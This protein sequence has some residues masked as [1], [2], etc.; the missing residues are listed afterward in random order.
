[1]TTDTE[2]CNRALGQAGARG[3]ITNMLT[4]TSPEAAACRTYYASTRNSL[5]RA[6]H[7]DFARFAAYVNVL[8]AL[9]GTPE[10]TSTGNA[11]WLP[12]YPQPPWIYS[13]AYPSDCVAVRYIVPQLFV[14]SSLIDGVPIFPVQQGTPYSSALCPIRPQKFKIGSDVDG[15]DNQIKC[16][17]SNQQNAIAIY[18]KL[19]T[20]PDLWDSTFEDAFVDSLAFRLVFPLSG[21]KNLRPQLKASAR[22]SIALAQ[23]RD[24]N[25]GITYDDS[26]PEWI[27]VHG[28]ANS[29]C[30]DYIGQCAWPSF[31]V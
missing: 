23:A 20:N 19:I 11:S 9:P 12:S 22:E 29:M 28:W 27:R 26:V 8:K 2:L 14:G 1:M 16:V 18:T 13:Y 4:N 15:N 3:S 5:L 6:A 24:G 7:W 17:L 10:N 31:L 30:A 21:D 25:E